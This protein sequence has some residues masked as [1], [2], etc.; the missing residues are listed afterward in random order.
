MNIL[1]I[2]GLTVSFGGRDGRFTVL[3]RVSLSL[4][5]GERLCV[6]G[7]SGS[8]KSVTA[9]SILRL[10]GVG[11]RIEE[12]SI[13]L[14]GV[15]L[16]SLGER[17]MRR[18]R[19]GDVSMVFQEP[20]TSLNPVL[21][22]GKQMSEP[23][24]VHCGLKRR[25]AW[26]RAV[27]MLRSVGLPDASGLMKKYPHQLSGGM[28]Q[29]VMIAMALASSPSVIIA[30]EPTTALDATVEAD[31]LDLLT[32]VCL[33]GGASMI[34]ITHDLAVVRRVA[35][36]VAVMYAGRVVE[37][38]S[39]DIIFSDTKMSHP[40]TEGLMLAIPR[41]KSIGEGLRP[42]PGSVPRPSEALCGCK[43][44][45]RCAYATPLCHEREPEL[46]SF[47]DGQR[48]R[49]HYPRKKERRSMKHE[50]AASNTGA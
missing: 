22:I 9:M 20:M 41:V 31:I 15:D 10:L 17:E 3:D 14:R 21:T 50:K 2:R 1:E 34:F 29:R 42:I 24:L 28:R 16:L 6:V 44:A 45:P 18:V 47:G 8:G 13:L 23:Y 39:C 12:G 7:E 35:D 5:E 26:G 11:G 30:D 38:G 43:F 37:E 36:R 48:I 46:L 40:Y 25:E 32:R 33:G 27:E 4:G 19:G 49:C